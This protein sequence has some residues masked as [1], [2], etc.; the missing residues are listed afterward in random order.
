M[1]GIKIA[2]LGDSLTKGVILTDKEKYSLVE[3]SFMD[4]ISSTLN[5]QVD[6][7]S[8]F[9]CTVNFGE[10]MIERHKEKISSSDYTFIEYG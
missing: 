1:K 2:A 3:F 7:Y 8:R 4:I 10:K 6:N 5:I 9:G